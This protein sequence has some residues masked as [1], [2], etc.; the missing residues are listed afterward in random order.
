MRSQLAQS[1]I[2]CCHCSRFRTAPTNR[3]R[4]QLIVARSRAD[5]ITE[6]NK[7]ARIDQVEP[8]PDEGRSPPNKAIAA[9]LFTVFVWALS[10]PLTK[11][12]LS[13]MPPLQLAA[14]RFA[15]ASVLIV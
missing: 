10:F 4:R 8:E 2:A 11:V 5:G 1:F 6:M 13:D 9:A 15:V 3:T 7:Q 14:A 12:A